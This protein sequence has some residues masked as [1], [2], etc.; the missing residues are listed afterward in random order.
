MQSNEMSCLRNSSLMVWV[1]VFHLKNTSL[2]QYKRLQQ[3]WIDVHCFMLNKYMEYKC[4]VN[5]H[6]EYNMLGNEN[7]LCGMH[8]LTLAKRLYFIH[9]LYPRY[10]FRSLFVCFCF[11][12]SI[13]KA[14]L[15]IHVTLCFQHDGSRD[16][17]ILTAATNYHL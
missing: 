16:M 4:V 13:R 15:V 3:I 8:L 17:N 12:F 6:G 10:L 1:A 11:C 14:C 2:I 5:V 9:L 7:E